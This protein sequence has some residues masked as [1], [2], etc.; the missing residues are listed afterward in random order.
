MRLTDQQQA[1]VDHDTGPALVFAVAGAGKTTAMVHRIGRLVSEGVFSAERILATS[2][3]KNNQRDLRQALTRWPACAPVQVSTLHALGRNIVMVARENGLL[4]TP[5]SRHKTGKLDQ[6]VL[7]IALGEARRRDV[8]YKRELNGLDR[9][10]F[11]DY[12][13]RNKGNLAYADLKSAHLPRSARKLASQAE[14]PSDKLAWYLPLYQLFEEMRQAQGWITFDDMLLTGWE[15]LQRFPQMREMWQTRYDCVLVDEFQDINLV[16]SELLDTLAAQRNYM[17][18]GDDDQTIYQWRGAHPRFILDF[19]KRY[20]AATYLITDNFRCPIGPL[21][22]ANRII[23]HNQQRRPKQLNLTKG[24][25]GHLHIT[26]HSN[27]EQMARD[28]VAAAMAEYAQGRRWRDIAVLVRLNAQTPHIEQQLIE[29]DIPYRVSKPF[30]ERFEIVTLI[31]YCRLAWIEQQMRLGK[32]LSSRQRSAFEQAWRDTHNRPKR[33][34][35]R[36]LH[37]SIRYAVVQLQMPFTDALRTHAERVS[38]YVAESLDMLADDM[39]WL[40]QQLEQSAETTLQQ[41]DWRLQFQMYLRDSSGNEQIGDGR[42]AG[43]AAFQLYAR[44]KGT[45]LQFMQHIRELAEHRNL[46]ADSKIDALTVSTIH[47]AKGLEWPVV[48][49]PHVN[50]GMLPFTGMTTFNLEEE[51]RLFYVAVTR[52]REKLSLHLLR[53]EDASQFLREIDTKQLL[54][55]IKQWQSIVDTARANG[56]LPVLQGRDAQLLAQL[57]Q[58]YA[59]QRYFQH[60]CTDSAQMAQAVVAW[61]DTQSPRALREQ[62]L[63]SADTDFWRTLAHTSP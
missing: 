22:L 51:R 38:P 8:P 5:Q 55:E 50:Q 19:P 36:D 31:A 12:V 43:V 11:L 18:I 7:N 49:V 54:H 46:Q 47:Q 17:A 52:T 40:A 44:G 4:T 61:L 34:I 27:V 63:N 29:H 41:L 58:R 15:L 56:S 2:F 6:L 60:Y 3:G 25:D 48:F 39:G 20:K 37:D 32:R 24:F 62:G 23:A 9:Q 33:Y 53:D 21:L 28:I 26:S 35:S 45:L 30:Y 10:D 13:G 1:V 42:A 57:T 14:P 16:Q 59:Q